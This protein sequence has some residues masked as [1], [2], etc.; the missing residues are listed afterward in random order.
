MDES[1]ENKFKNTPP[2]EYDTNTYIPDWFQY[3]IYY[4]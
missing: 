1:T 4:I 3:H 2:I